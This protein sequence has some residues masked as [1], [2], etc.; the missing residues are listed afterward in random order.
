MDTSNSAPSDTLTNHFIAGLQAHDVTLA[1]IRSG[2]WKYCGGNKGFRLDY[3]KIACPG[4]E[5]PEL[6]ENCVCGHKIVENCY[7]TNGSHILVLGNSCI[8]RFVPKS[9][10]T[11]DKCDGPHRNRV[12]NRCNACRSGI[13]DSCDR[14]CNPKY[15][16]CW[17]CGGLD[18]V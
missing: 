8:K 2:R 4:E 16:K 11:C 6:H 17:F 18:A 13:C 5:L 1:E 15:K 3:F 10:R 9:S 14:P 7:I 12:V